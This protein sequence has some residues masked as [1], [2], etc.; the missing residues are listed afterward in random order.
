M[1]K[2]SKNNVDELHDPEIDFR[3]P[4]LAF[5]SEAVLTDRLVE[6]LKIC[7]LRK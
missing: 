2:T 3:N 6:V 5:T 4:F 7:R 1:R